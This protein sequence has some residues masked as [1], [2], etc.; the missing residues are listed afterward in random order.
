MGAASERAQ[1]APLDTDIAAPGRC[2][3]QRRDSPPS[4]AAR[5]PAG[6]A[7]VRAAFLKSCDHLAAL[8]RLLV[9]AL[10]A[11]MTVIVLVA[12]FYRYVLLDALSWTEEASRYLMI[13]MGFL[14]TGLVVREGG[15]IAV[16]LLPQQL[17]GLRRRVV[18]ALVR[19][20]GLVF[21]AAVVGA[22]LVLAYRV[23]GQRTPVLAI[24]MMW[25]YLAIPVGCLLT[26]LETIALMLREPGQLA[27][28]SPAELPRA[29]EVGG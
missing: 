6:G 25:P 10:M 14:G 19:L 23:A 15:H 11:A 17:T 5:P 9:M 2:P 12:V 1:T 27:G 21:L 7:E 16:D 26:G 4:R 8:V 22:G 18:L 3:P 13:W 28:T 29:A 24:S 20:L